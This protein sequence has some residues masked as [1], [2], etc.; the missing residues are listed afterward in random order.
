[1]YYHM[2]ICIIIS[3]PLTDGVKLQP[4][5]VWCTMEMHLWKL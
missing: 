3:N 4:R 2:H 5:Q 1:M